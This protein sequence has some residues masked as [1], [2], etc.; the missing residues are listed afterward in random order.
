MYNNNNYQNQGNYQQQNQ[1]FQ[2]N[3]YQQQISC[4]ITQPIAVISKYDNDERNIHNTKELN[5]VSWNNR[6]A[7]VDIR[8]WNIDPG[9]GQKTAGKGI[10]FTVQE[11]QNLCAYLISAGFGPQN[12]NQ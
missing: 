11:A 3:G 6:P 8:R 1:G 4:E 10:S 2:Q 7:S 9:T 12:N 5:M